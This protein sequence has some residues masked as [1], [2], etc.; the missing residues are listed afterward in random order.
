MVDV[1]PLHIKQARAAS[2]RQPEHPFEVSLGDARNLGGEDELYDAVLLLG[3]LY[4]L[5]EREERLV[6]LSEAYRVLRKG[7]FLFAAAISRFASLIDGLHKEMLDD[8]SYKEI[9]EEGLR[10]GRHLPEDPKY[11]TTAFFHHP[12]ELADE[13]KE[14]DFDI[15]GLFA[16]EGPAWLLSDIAERCKSKERRDQLLYSIRYIEQ[17][18]SVL[19][20]S[21]HLLAVCCKK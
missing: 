12:D 2:A 14:S 17:E 7:G 3:P 11:F 19:G 21:A 15:T 18:P 1:V 20:I 5:I 13:L 8:P 16:V 6:A 9:V 10:S 4:H